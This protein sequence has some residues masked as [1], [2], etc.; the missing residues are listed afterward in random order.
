[1]EFALT[2]VVIA[3]YRRASYTQHGTVTTSGQGLDWHH[4]C[5]GS[6]MAM[7]TN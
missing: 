7:T 6:T 3:Y 5:Q 1:L 4:S 2:N